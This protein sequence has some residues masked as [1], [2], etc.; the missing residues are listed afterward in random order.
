[1]TGGFDGELDDYLFEN[2]SSSPLPQTGQPIVNQ[3]G[4]VEGVDPTTNLTSTEQALLSPEEQI[5][6]QRLR[7]T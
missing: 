7:T 4:G 2:I 1:M 3:G 6:R 5:I